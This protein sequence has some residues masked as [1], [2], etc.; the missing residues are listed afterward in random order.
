[1]GLFYGWNEMKAIR[2]DHRISVNPHEV[3]NALR[4]VKPRNEQ[5]EGGFTKKLKNILL[6]DK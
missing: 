4:I 5:E 3:D 1:M 2:K 6:S